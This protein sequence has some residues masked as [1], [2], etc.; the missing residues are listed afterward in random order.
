MWYQPNVRSKKGKRGERTQRVAKE[1]KRKRGEYLKVAMKRVAKTMTRTNERSRAIKCATSGG[2][3]M[4]K[5]SE[6]RRDKETNELSVTEQ[7]GASRTVGQKNKK[8][9]KATRQSTRQR[10]G[11]DK[12]GGSMI[13]LVDRK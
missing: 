4:N 1:R 11:V 10:K 9:E 3:A 13:H 2:T 7:A 6:E 8:S 12:M 5:A